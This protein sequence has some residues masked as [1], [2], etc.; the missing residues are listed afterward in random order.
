MNTKQQGFTLIELVVVIVI[1]GILAAV[2]VPRFVNLQSD[3]RT[4]VL[5]GMEGSVRGAASLIYAQALAQNQ[6][7]ATGTVTV[8]GQSI[9]LVFGYPT[10]ASIV[11]AVNVSGSNVTAV[12]G[13]AGG[14]AAQFN[15]T[16]VTTQASCRVSYT[17]PAAANNAPSIALPGTIDCN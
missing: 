5:R 4:A 3:A 9:A 14:A 17:Q 8:E 2:A 10:N 13:V 1:L 6:A 12:A 16:G 7:G 15:V 11:N